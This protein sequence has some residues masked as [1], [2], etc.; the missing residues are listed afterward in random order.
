MHLPINIACASLNFQRLDSQSLGKLSSAYL[1]NDVE[2]ISN[3]KKELG[4]QVEQ[5]VIIE[6]CNAVMVI[7]CYYDNLSKDF[8]QGRV[9]SVWDK[10]SRSGVVD[11]IKSIKFFENSEAIRYLGECSVGLHSVTIGDSQVLSQVSDA[12]QI[13]IKIQPTNPTFPIISLWIKSLASEVKLRTNL[14]AGNTSL[15]RIAA[16]IVS[17]KI[18]KGGTISLIGYGKTGKLIAKILNNEL[19]YHLKI[20][21][22]SA[23]ALAEIKKEKN[24]DVVEM[25]DYSN[26]LD[27]QCIVVAISSNGETEEYIKSLL[28]QVEKINT[29]PKLLV[30][31]AS[32]SLLLRSMSEVRIINIEDISLEANNNIDKRKSEINKSREIINKY[33]FTA[34]DSLKKEIGKITFNKQKKEIAC[35]LDDEKL[36]I[37][38]IRNTGYK[39]IRSFLDKM[40]F[41]EV[42]TPYI[43]GISTD[44]PKVDKGGAINVSWQDGSQAFLRQSNQ[45]YKQM[46]VVSGLKKIYE[47]GPF[48]R[49]ETSQSY[50][51]LQESIG[52]D[53][54]FSQPKNLDEVYKLA[55]SMILDARKRI[56]HSHQI[57][58]KN[59]ILP[60]IDLV[61]V[62]TYKEAVGILNSRGHNIALGE[63]LGLIGE[64]KL[65][66]IIKRERNSDVFVV[67]NYP[68]TIKKFYT[69][70]IDDGLTETFD[71]IMAGWELASGAIRE[72]DRSSIEKSMRLSGIDPGDYSFYLS[73]VDGSESHGGFGLGIDRLFAKLL[74][75]EMVSDAVVFP[76]TFKNL[77]P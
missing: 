59:L 71:I 36:K 48:W 44:P 69:K 27:S 6:K 52:L 67:R 26:L 56:E 9:L 54:E 16:E 13:A 50:R 15:E 4:F 45:I 39:S 65:G 62:M 20:A 43:V 35:K 21:N 75:L 37:F 34:V 32:P 2:T 28:G 38:G 47:I 8:I 77:I 55:Y 24:V 64:A 29:K 41:I 11:S 3:F 63:D 5:L 76:R 7:F 12:L 53:V 30:D 74:D 10:L 61:P 19:G 51:H 18:E 31:L 25:A 73:I 33:V 57:K 22:R 70:K 66:Q 1:N 68:D 60:D 49:A 40:G 72:T 17:Q 42:T 46:I 58:N 23:D 14:F